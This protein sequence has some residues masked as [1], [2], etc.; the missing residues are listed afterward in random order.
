MISS[1]F[2]TLSVTTDA[3]AAAITILSAVPILS[4]YRRVNGNFNIFRSMKHDPLHHDL[5]NINCGTS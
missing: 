5:D 1:R 4:T 3:A 2:R